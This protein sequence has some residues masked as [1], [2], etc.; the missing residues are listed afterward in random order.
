MLLLLLNNNR[1]WKHNHRNI[2]RRVAN[3]L[4]PIKVRIHFQS[5][6][7]WI[8]ETS[9]EPTYA[10]W[11]AKKHANTMHWHA[12]GTRPLKRDEVANPLMPNEARFYFQSKWNWIRET[13]CEPT[14]AHRSAMKHAT[15]MQW[16][17]QIVRWIAF[18]WMLSKGNRLSHTTYLL[19]R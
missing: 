17:G 3:P 9:C 13:S 4:M 14:Y 10:H 5:N 8:R 18:P 6:W 1:E 11:N 15:A 7:N 19:F 16:H 2:A 12:V